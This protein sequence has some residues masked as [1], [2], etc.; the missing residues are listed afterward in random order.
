MV[1][2]WDFFLGPKALKL[3]GPYINIYRGD[4]YTRISISNISDEY[5]CPELEQQKSKLIFL[6]QFQETEAIL[7]TIVLNIHN[8]ALLSKPSIKMVS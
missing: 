6:N 1:T 8:I 7:R 3:S 5:T 2:F 4:I